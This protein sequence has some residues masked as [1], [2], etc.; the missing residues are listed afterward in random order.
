M[1]RVKSKSCVVMESEIFH[2]PGKT[3]ESGQPMVC[4][5]PPDMN[6]EKNQFFTIKSLLFFNFF[7]LH[8]EYKN[9]K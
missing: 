5:V 1:R 2:H 9:K 3:R 8:L 7:L 4:K 6:T